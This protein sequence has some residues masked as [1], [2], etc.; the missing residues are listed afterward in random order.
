MPEGSGVGISTRAF[1]VGL[2]LAIL[3]SSVGTYMAIR[4]SGFE[5]PQGLAGDMGLPGEQGP[6]GD[7]GPQG[8]QGP[9]GPQG[10]EG[11]QGP[12][13]PQSIAYNTTSAQFFSTKN[14]ET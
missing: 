8:E 4:L 7:P 12:P 6:K 9:T 5:G 14:T 11:E 13:G 2:I 10:I 1:A 3:V